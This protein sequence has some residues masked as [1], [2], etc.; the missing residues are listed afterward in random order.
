MGNQSVKDFTDYNWRDASEVTGEGN[1]SDGKSKDKI[2]EPE[3]RKVITKRKAKVKPPSNRSL[4]ISSSRFEVQRIRTMVEDN[5]VPV[6]LALLTDSCYRI[7]LDNKPVNHCCS[8]LNISLPCNQEWRRFLPNSCTTFCSKC[9]K[10]YYRRRKK[11][12]RR[13]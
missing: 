13:C 11:P 8:Q 4:Q 7:R 2:K 10:S 5:N 1:G 3:T 9:R 12:K 6:V